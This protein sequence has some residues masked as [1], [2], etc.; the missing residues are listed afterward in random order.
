MT[1]ALL[2]VE[3]IGVRYDAVQALFD[4][5][6]E[7]PEGS[8]VALLGANG[9]GKS[10]FARTASGLVPP[11]EGVMTFAGADITHWPPYQIRRSGLV[12]IPEGRGVFP[13]L[14]VH[15]NIRMALRRVDSAAARQS[16]TDY[17]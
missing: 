6:L 5:S 11:F 13:D 17:A 15:E 14:T 7:V 16:A 4:V 10:T 2:S 3:H 1:D 8:V 12:H 9:A